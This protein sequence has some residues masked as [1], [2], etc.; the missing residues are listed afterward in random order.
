MGAPVRT[1]DGSDTGPSPRPW[2]PRTAW[3]PDSRSARGQATVSSSCVFPSEDDGAAAHAGA[4]V[5]AGAVGQ[6]DL[7]VR[8]LHRGMG[9]TAELADGLDDLGDAAAVVG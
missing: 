5:A 2:R 3:S 9:L 1:R 4:D 8:H 6:C 7:T